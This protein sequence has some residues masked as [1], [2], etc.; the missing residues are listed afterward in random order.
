MARKPGTQPLTPWQ[1]F[2]NLISGLTGPAIYGGAVTVVLATYF[3][4]LRHG[5]IAALPVMLKFVSMQFTPFFMLGYHITRRVLPD[6]TVRRTTNLLLPALEGTLAVLAM[7]A[8]MALGFE[9]EDPYKNMWLY[10]AE[11]LASILTA[12]LVVRNVFRH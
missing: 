1:R 11:L 7:S 10:A 5:D 6:K 8:I 12:R 3:A 4:A 2:L 9:L